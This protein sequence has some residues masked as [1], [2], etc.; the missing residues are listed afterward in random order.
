ML[1]LSDQMLRHFARHAPPE[2][3]EARLNAMAADLGEGPFGRR[4]AREIVNGQ[5]STGDRQREIVNGRSSTGSGP[6][7]AV[8]EGCAHYKAVVRD[9]I[10]FFGPG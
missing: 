4:V 9:G 5:S 7:Q 6:E 8:P 3:I 2:A 10:E 1:D